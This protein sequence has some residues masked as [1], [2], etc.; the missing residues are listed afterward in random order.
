VRGGG[1]AGW[2]RGGVGA[3]VA[4]LSLPAARLARSAWRLL[5]RRLPAWWT[6]GISLSESLLERALFLLSN[7]SYLYGAVALWASGAPPVLGS[8]LLA[9]CAV[10]S[11]YHFAQ[12]ADGCESASAARWLVTDVALASST[13]LV[14]WLHCRPTPAALALGAVSLLLFLDVP[15]WGYATSHSLWHVSTAAMACTSAA[16][17][18]HR[19]AR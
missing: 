17:L 19:T 3:A 13:A 18:R 14:F 2:A 5:P 11:A 6:A 1:L 8:L 7:A 9:V 15:Q 4:A 12:C 10:S 16:A